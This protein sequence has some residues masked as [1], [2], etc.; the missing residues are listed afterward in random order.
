MHSILIV[1]CA[2]TAKSKHITKLLRFKIEVQACSP[3]RRA[4]IFKSGIFDTPKMANKK[5]GRRPFWQFNRQDLWP[6]KA[7]NFMSDH[8]LAHDVGVCEANAW[9]LIG[10]QRLF[11]PLKVQTF[12][13]FISYH[14]LAIHVHVGGM[15][16]MQGRWFVINEDF[17][18]Q[19]SANLS[20]IWHLSTTPWSDMSTWA[21]VLCLSC[22]GWWTLICIRLSM[23]KQEMFKFNVQ[24]S[25]R[26]THLSG[27]CVLCCFVR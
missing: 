16:C 22:F 17:F 2:C 20:D 15:G 23:I 3:S 18:A 13:A 11:L 1:Q 10:L 8:T 25:N 27:F 9:L 4:E 7:Q 6:E 21:A 14:T 19:K 24:D 12:H 26:S 5:R